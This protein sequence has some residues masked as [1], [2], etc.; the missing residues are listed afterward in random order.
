MHVLGNVGVSISSSKVA[1]HSLWGATSDDTN[2]S[3]P[4]KSGVA[5]HFPSQTG[6]RKLRPS[7]PHARPVPRGTDKHISELAWHKTRRQGLSHCKHQAVGRVVYLHMIPQAS[8]CN[9]LGWHKQLSSHPHT[10]LTCTAC[11]IAGRRRRQANRQATHKPQREALLA[12]LD[13]NLLRLAQT[14]PWEAI[15]KAGA[16]HPALRRTTRSTSCKS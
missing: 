15:G 2:R 11:L 14:A 4:L 8:A 13:F 9:P 5:S 10:R 12:S 3:R 1:C 16:G 7:R 6:R